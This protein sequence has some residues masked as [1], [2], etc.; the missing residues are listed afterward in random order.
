VARSSTEVEYRAMAMATTEL[1]WLRML[2]KD[3]HL[4]L[5]TPPIILCD[6]LGAMALASNPIYHARLSI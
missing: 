6:N 3:L 1:Y 4:P 2:L 5:T